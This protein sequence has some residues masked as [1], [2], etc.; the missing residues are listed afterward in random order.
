MPNFGG[1]ARTSSSH[2]PA[3]ISK[4]QLQTP[5]AVPTSRRT[6]AQITDQQC[7][8]CV[9]AGFSQKQTNFC[10][11]SVLCGLNSQSPSSS[12]SECCIKHC[13]ADGCRHSRRLLLRRIF[14]T[15]RM[16]Q[17]Q[18]TS[19]S[20]SDSQPAAAVPGQLS[21]AGQH[22]LSGCNHCT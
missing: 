8:T 16:L 9:P 14:T 18:L 2:L 13:S 11:Q 4:E 7:P 22:C 19:S 1:V 21:L 10:L 3:L 12:E 20:G 6:K 15:N 17:P 5:G